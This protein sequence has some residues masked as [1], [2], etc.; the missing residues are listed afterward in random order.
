MHLFER[1]LSANERVRSANVALALRV[2]KNLALA[3]MS[4]RAS[5]DRR[6]QCALTPSM[7]IIRLPGVPGRPGVPAPPPWPKPPGMKKTAL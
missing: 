4:A 3:L 1:I 6:T 7:E 5:A 2:S